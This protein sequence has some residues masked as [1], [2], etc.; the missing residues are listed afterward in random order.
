MGLFVFLSSYRYLSLPNGCTAVLT[1]PTAQNLAN[2]AK[3]ERP[4]NPAIV[5]GKKT[6]LGVTA[7]PPPAQQASVVAETGVVAKE[8]KGGTGA[9]STIQANNAAGNAFEKQVVGQVQ[10]T[11]SEVVQQVTLKTEGGVKTCMDIMGRDANG[12]IVYIECKASP[13]AP[14][15]KNQTVA[16]PEIQ[17]SG[18][19]IVGQGKPGFPGGTKIPPTTVDIIRL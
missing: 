8:A 11:H 13:T 17:K 4:P 9:K 12:N 5:T 15:T 6:P 18:A 2:A 10:Q 16:F 19:T 3:Q 1:K 14:L 7:E